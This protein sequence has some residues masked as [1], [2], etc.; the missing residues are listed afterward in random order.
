MHVSITV[1]KFGMRFSLVVISTSLEYSHAWNTE[2]HDAVGA[3]AMS[4]IDSAASSKLKGILGGQDASEVASWSHRIEQSVEWTKSLHYLAQENDW[5][6][7]SPSSSSGS[8]CPQGHCLSSAIRHFYTQA[9]RG[10]LNDAKNVMVDSAG[11]TDADAIRFIIGL[12]GD[13]AQPLHTGFK[14]NDFGKKITVR[15]PD[16]PGF[17][18]A[19]TSLYDVWDN[20]LIDHAV[21]N[22]YSPNSWWSGWTHVRSVNPSTVEHERKVWEQKGIDAV[23]DWI[24]DSAEYAC[25]RVYSN[26]LTSEKFALVDDP[27]NPLNIPLNV[28]TIWEREMKERILISGIRLGLLLNDILVRKDAPAASKLRRGSAV[29]D[30]SAVN[31]V[32]ILETFDDLDD[33][34]NEVSPRSK[35]SPVVGYNA[36]FVNVGILCLVVLIVLIAYKA[37]ATSSSVTFRGTKTQIVEMVGPSGK[38]LNSH[39]D[40]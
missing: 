1:E 18:S 29:N 14:S 26:P 21:N 6:C 30:P 3:T 25:K 23:E 17:P 20:Q 10:D 15:I 2:G 9:T 11:F 32:D 36:G 40:D 13:L 31:A 28:F 24:N 34:G 16:R 27:S 38:K 7:K 19:V 33:R 8:T 5:A 22:P 12:V 4:M 37:G 35:T 39:R